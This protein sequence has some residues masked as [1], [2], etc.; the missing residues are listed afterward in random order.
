MGLCL[1]PRHD[2]IP[3]SPLDSGFNWC[4]WKKGAGGRVWVPFL[5]GG[6]SLKVCHTEGDIVWSSGTSPVFLLNIQQRP[7]EKRLWMTW[8][9]LHLS[10]AESL[11]YC[12]SKQS[13]ATHSNWFIFTRIYGG[14]SSPWCFA[15]CF[16]ICTSCLPRGDPSCIGFQALSLPCNLSSLLASEYAIILWVFQHFVI[17]I[18]VATLFPD[19]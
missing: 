11:S 16:P 18:M 12:A 9:F 5:Q 1:G 4:M 6:W 17:A 13:L 2:K 10:F 8:I 19:S 14:P 7:M 3:A 15:S